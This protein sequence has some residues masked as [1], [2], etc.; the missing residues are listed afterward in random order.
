MR[1]FR[2]IETL[3]DQEETAPWLFGI[4]RNVSLEVRKARRVRARVLSSSDEELEG[5]LRGLARDHA[6]ERAPRARAAEII[7]RALERLNERRALLLLRLDHG[8]AYRDRRR[9]EF[10]PR[11]SEG[12]DPSSAADP[13]RRARPLS[14]DRS[15]AR[16]SGA[17]RSRTSSLRH[18]LGTAMPPITAVLAR[19][20]RDRCG[21]RG[22]CASGRCSRRRRHRNRRGRIHGARRARA[23]RRGDGDRRRAAVGGR[24]LR[25]P[26]RDRGPRPR[27]EEHAY[28]ALPQ[29]HAELRRHGAKSRTRPRATKNRRAL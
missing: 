25:G 3:R 27:R 23:G 6:G 7:A 21:G 10:F 5:D 9:D 1:A 18:A 12:R 13:P 24:A 16:R 29:R 8:L 17:P 4:A 20:R 26:A 22:A 15:R 28:A 11:E 14:G 2:R 19:A